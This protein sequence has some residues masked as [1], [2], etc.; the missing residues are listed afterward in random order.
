MIIAVD[1]EGIVLEIVKKSLVKDGY[2]VETFGSATAALE[3]LANVDPELII[4]DV[5]MPEVGGFEFRRIY[6][7]RFGHRG[8]PFVFLSSLSDTKDI[9]AG[10]SE[11]ADDYLT[12]P[13]EPALL[14][15]K[16]KAIIARKQRFSTPKFHGD[17]AKFPFVR[18]M[19]FCEAKGLTG[20]VEIISEGVGARLTFRAGEFLPEA[21]DDA[22]LER[23]Y[24]I[25]SGTFTIYSRAV[26]F[27]EIEEM[28]AAPVPAQQQ[29]AEAPKM[30][31]PMGLLSG[32]KFENRLFQ[33]Q[34][35][36]VT[37]PS[38]QVVTIVVLDGRVVSKRV[39]DVP[40]EHDERRAVEKFMERCHKEV[41]DDVRA[42]CDDLVQKKKKTEES[43]EQR[44][45]K[46]FDDGFELY[47]SGKY[48]E[49]LALMQEALALKPGDK[50]LETNVRMLN[51]K[52]GRE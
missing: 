47:R 9:V 5:M 2:E 18:L 11:G 41:E 33:L 39:R 26:D 35:E 20:D 17:I 34:T 45:A 38:N 52:L 25:Q 31:K 21:V 12:K 23:L 4:S 36:F 40:P 22:V 13:I 44:A 49:A 29:K 15:A 51:K 24:D 3:A 8:T 43:P 16:V 42:R 37:Q 27:R 46:L 28:A 7:E 32:V 1:D 30:E 6:M 10:L 48:E 50:L 14:V 19:Q